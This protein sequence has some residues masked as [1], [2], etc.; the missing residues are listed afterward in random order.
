MS[1]QK[2][3]ILYTG[4]TIGMG[5]KNPEV[6]N[7][8]LV[9]QKWNQIQKFMPSIQPNGYFSGVRNIEF[10]YQSLPEILDSSQ[11]GTNHWLQM[12][13]VID[14]NYTDFDGFIIIH[15]TD[16]MAYTAS[17]LSFLLQNLGK[18]VVLTG[19]QLP[20]SH[21]RT[22]AINNL[23]N[24]IHIAAAASFGLPIVPEVCICFN[25][26]LFRGNRSTK[27]STNDFEGFVS[28]N[29][30]AL[31]DLEQV[32]KFHPN[33]ILKKP[34]AVFSIKPQL[35]TKV[36]DIGLFPGLQPSLLR[37]LVD[38]EEVDGLILKTY[39]A[40]NA[41]CTSEFVS[42]LKEARNKGT[43]I[44]FI[45]QCYQGGVQLGKYEASSAFLDMGVISGGDMTNESALAKMV[46][47][48]GQRLGVS[49]TRRLLETNLCGERSY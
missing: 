28:P 48:L 8:P 23:S 30:P 6:I 34:K 14:S 13:E 27:A 12:A 16:T 47:V 19:S 25:D 21:S 20:I 22:D 15:G 35:S 26:R 38:D 46:W 43:H 2:V 29:Y 3:L 5:Y 45:T 44:L 31:A 7:S 33:T 40:G 1:S 4:G 36:M 37:K 42:V 18:P 10:T 11:M 9:P 49:E 32:I 39:G 17:G 24:A 41:P